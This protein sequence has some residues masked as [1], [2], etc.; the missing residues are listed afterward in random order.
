VESW[1]IEFEFGGEIDVS[2]LL[3]DIAAGYTAR[4]DFVEQLLS[5]GAV[6]QTKAKDINTIKTNQRPQEQNQDQTSHKES[7]SSSPQPEAQS[8]SQ[9]D[10]QLNLSISLQRPP[11]RRPRLPP[12]SDPFLSLQGRR[13][14]IYFR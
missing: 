7:E 9:S 13:L 11:P 4:L 12:P 5:E 8:Q 6:L 10:P 2:A 1:P 14:E 3:H